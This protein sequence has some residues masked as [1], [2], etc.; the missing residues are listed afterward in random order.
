MLRQVG[1]RNAPSPLA[2]A[3]EPSELLETIERCIAEGDRLWSEN[4]LQEADERYRSGLDAWA[5]ASGDLDLGQAGDKAR[6]AA[7]LYSRRGLLLAS[8][9]PARSR[10]L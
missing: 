4:N 2:G 8:V 3:Q 6:A 1:D 9:G 7:R 10:A 5:R